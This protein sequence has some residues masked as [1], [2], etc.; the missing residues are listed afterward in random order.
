MYFTNN[1]GFQVL[2]VLEC[3][4]LTLQ[5]K[6]KLPWLRG[7]KP[8]T[9]T[10]E[11]FSTPTPPTSSALNWPT[12]TLLKNPSVSEEDGMSH[13]SRTILLAFL[14]LKSH[15]SIKRREQGGIGYFLFEYGFSEWEEPCQSPL[16]KA[17]LCSLG[18]D[19]WWLIKSEVRLLTTW[20]GWITPK[21]AQIR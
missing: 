7:D 16:P 1:H 10:D 15:G 21:M 20:Y 8:R 12:K 11:P 3:F 5:S 19:G 2:L 13:G 6:A 18:R 9:K 4:I 17:S 14:E